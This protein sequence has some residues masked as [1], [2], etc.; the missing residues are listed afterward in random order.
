M[1]QNDNIAIIILAAGSSS[2]MGQAKQLLPWGGSNLLNHCI[3]Q[4]KNSNAKEVFVVLGANYEAI[5][6]SVKNEPITI[7]RNPGWEKGIGESIAFGVKKIASKKFDGVLI[8][9]ADQPQ[10]DIAFLNKLITRFE[11]SPKAIIATGYKNSVG[12]PAVFNKSYFEDLMN[13]TGDKG[14]K[15]F[16]ELQQ[17]NVLVLS[18]PTTIVDIDTHKDYLSLKS[19]HGH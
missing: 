10:I 15:Q 19:S 9:L 16:V 11:T 18:F 1:N 5:N 4:A 7:L 6:T 13:L 2:R 8:M 17:Y 12:V 14:A 3:I